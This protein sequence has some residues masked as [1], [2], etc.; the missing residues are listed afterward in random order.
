MMDARK[1]ISIDFDTPGMKAFDWALSGASIGLGLYWSSPLWI[2]AGVLG[3]VAAWYRPLS[4]M[5]RYLQG[6]VKSRR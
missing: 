4:R 2:V 5:Q 1:M 6:F 3:G